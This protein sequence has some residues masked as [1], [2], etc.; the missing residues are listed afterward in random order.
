[1]HRKLIGSGQNRR[2]GGKKQ[3][4]QG[5]V[6]DDFKNGSMSFLHKK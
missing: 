6:N 2:K 1:L 4:R 5:D 3:G